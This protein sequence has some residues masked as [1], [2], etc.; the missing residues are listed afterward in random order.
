MIDKI[1]L[2]NR[3][4]GSSYE[5]FIIAEMS[6]NHNKSLDNALDIVRAAAVAGVHA[7]KLQTYTA[8]TITIDSNDDSFRLDIPQSPWS[9]RTLYDLYQEAHTPWDWHK[10]IMDLCREVGLI[11]FSTPFDETAVDFLEGLNVPA[12]KIASFENN[13][14]PLIRKV[15]ST[16][17][18]VIISTG[19]ASIAELEEAVTA[20][21]QAGCSNI[22]LLK[23]TS[24]YPA[25]PDNANIRTIPHL[26]DMF[27][28]QVGLSDHTMG[29]GVAVA[30]IALGATMIEKHF[31][32]RRADGGVDSSFSMEPEEMKMLVSE[33][34][35]AWR[36]LGDVKYGPTENEKDL[37]KLRRS[38][39]IVRD[40]KSGEKITR[41]NLRCIRPSFGLPTKY[42]DVF[43]GKRAKTDIRKGTPVTWD[44]I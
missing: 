4:I 24:A 11:C 40:I 30:S 44:M 35:Q 28:L 32:L 6:G 20:A 41:E 2:G 1:L 26:R 14:I 37:L 23:C 15:A 39:Y 3:F 17:K 18:P 10:P 22:I 34:L 9:K 29:T 42:F 33:T 5:P 38:L 21:R 25:S 31:T 13:H 19:M 8:D 12:Y 36:S 43:L 16:G 27:G 7:V